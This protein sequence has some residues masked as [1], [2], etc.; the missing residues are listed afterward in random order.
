MDLLDGRRVDSFA[1]RALVHVR[2][3]EEAGEQDKVGKVH[4]QR[5]FDVLLADAAPF[6]ALF[7]L[8]SSNKKFN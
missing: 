5:Q 8:K 6:A 1:R 7:Q 4:E 3:V 2:L